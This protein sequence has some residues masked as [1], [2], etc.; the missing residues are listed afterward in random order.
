MTTDTTYLSCAETAKLV[1]A[2]LKAA[3]PGVKFSVR[4][5]T[6]SGGASIDVHWTD[7]PTD[8]AISA[9]TDRYVGSQFDSTIDL[10]TYCAHYLLPDGTVVFAGTPG[11]EGSRGVL[12][13]IENDAPAGARRVHFGADHIFT[14]R[15]FSERAEAMIWARSAYWAGFERDEQRR[16]WDKHTY[17]HRASTEF[18]FTG[19]LRGGKPTFRPG[20]LNGAWR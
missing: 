20:D 2:A 16:E 10:K 5:D 8:K 19:W 13:R 17:F 6:Y 14:H 7:G 12:P 9:V 11:T 4:S 18:D 15:H 1:R 3:F